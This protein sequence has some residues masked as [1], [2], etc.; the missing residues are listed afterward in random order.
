M[1]KAEMI[2]PFSSKLCKE[3][4]LYRGRHYYLCFCKRYRGYVGKSGRV[5]NISAPCTSGAGSSKGFEMPPIRHPSAVDPFSMPLK[6]I[7]E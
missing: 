6:D 4:A 1:A 5:A 3:C 7:Q 2:C